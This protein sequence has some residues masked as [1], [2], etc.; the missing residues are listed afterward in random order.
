MAS[1]VSLHLLLVTLLACA[2][3]LSRAGTETTNSATIQTEP[4]TA[5]SIYYRIWSIPK[6]YQNPDNPII[7]EFDVIGRFQFDYFNVKSDRGSTSFAEIRR[8]RL[9]EDAWFA[10]GHLEIMTEID[11]ALRSFNTASIFYN[12]FTNLYGK[13]WICDAFNVRFGKFEPH[14][15]YDREFSDTQQKFFERSFYDDQII[16]GTD[17]TP[18][19]EVSGKFGHLG[20]MAMIYSTNT[21]KE[22][23]RF[24][25]GQGY[26]AELSYDFSK[27]LHV[28]KA[29]WALDYLHADGKS[30]TTNVF[31]HCRDA[32]ATYFDF[33][34]QR[35]SLVTQ[36]GY[37]HQVDH[38]GDIFDFHIMPSYMLTDKLEVTFRYEL[39]LAS[40][41]N[42]ISS[43]NREQQTVGTFSG[44]N[45]NAGYLG[46][47]YYLY[48]MKL[49]LMAG[50]EYAN[51]TG[52]TG[53]KA[54]FSGWTT[55][56]GFR[57]YF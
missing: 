30:P 4:E 27:P 48:G 46:L 10:K 1:R 22:L 35:F 53:P 29:L 2:P 45:Y 7:E 12:R 49:R 28:T 38:L 24:D 52:G 34:N 41:K 56:V 19:V 31:T 15:G 40:E 32:A 9:G 57:L 47:N 23:G 17:Y 33:T 43:L 11:T 42:G 36:F 16:G 51:L 6:V 13:L 21:N 50:E 25:G 18:G 26:Q 20:Y 8:F 39:G 54:N 55:W 37:D 5:D 14:F 3:A 44:N